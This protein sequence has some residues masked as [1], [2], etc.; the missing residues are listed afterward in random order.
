M[1]NP[2]P[3]ILRCA[4]RPFVLFVNYCRTLSRLSVAIWGTMVLCT[5]AMVL[6]AF[7]GNPLGEANAKFYGSLD[8]EQTGVNFYSR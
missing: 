1:L 5:G 7:K 6:L 3:L 4:L 8:S 2:L